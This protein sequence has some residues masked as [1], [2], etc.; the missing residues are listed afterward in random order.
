MVLFD[1]ML[2]ERRRAE[3]LLGLYSSRRPCGLGMHYR[4]GVS[5][6]LTTTGRTKGSSEFHGHQRIIIGSSNS[7][8]D[9]RAKARHDDTNGEDY[10]IP[11]DWWSNAGILK[12][13]SRPAESEAAEQ[14]KSNID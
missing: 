9:E 12:Q 4:S 6:R 5:S 8:E 11:V 7:D 10:P 2:K 3:L 13:A 14:L 1:I